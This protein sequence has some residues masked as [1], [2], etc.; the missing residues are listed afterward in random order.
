[1]IEHEDN[2]IFD[3][4]SQLLALALHDGIF[5]ATIKDVAH[6]YTVPIPPHRKG[7]HLKIKKEKLDIPIF[8]EPEHTP[9]GYRTSDD[10]P[11]KSRTWSRNIKRIGVRNGQELNLTQKVLRRGG[12]NAIN[13]KVTFCMDP[14]LYN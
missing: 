7:I 4:L 11:L 8:R 6:I 1:M 3:L 2:L 12:I 5:A 14:R 9:E 10:Q 13:S